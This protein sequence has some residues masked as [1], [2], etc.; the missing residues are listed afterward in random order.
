MSSR[1]YEF[2]TFF[3]VYAD[4]F[5]QASLRWRFC[6]ERRALA[7]Q[8]GRTAAAEVDVDVDCVDEVEAETDARLE[9]LYM[10]DPATLIRC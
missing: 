4:Y 6:E 7:V 10:F 1:G 3:F 2:W 9:S 5:Y 8:H